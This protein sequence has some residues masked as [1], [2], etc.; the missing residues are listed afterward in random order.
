MSI[1][2]GQH[3]S[4]PKLPIG[5][6]PR[7]LSFDVYGTLINTPPENLQAFR[8]ILHE[9]SETN[10]HSMEFYSFWERRN[11]AHYMEPYRSYKEI[12]QLSLSEAFRR[13]GVSSGREELITRYF[14]S[15]PR[16]GSTPMF[17]LPWTSWPRTTGWR[18]S[19]TSTMTFST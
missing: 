16:C 19:R 7:M 14:E 8:S 4:K 5:I 18:L 6:E 1:G 10:V 3:A 13:F 9:A 15:S 17:N 2:T 12:C 11:V